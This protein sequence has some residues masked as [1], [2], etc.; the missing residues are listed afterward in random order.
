MLNDK[1]YSVTT[2][3]DISMLGLNKFHVLKIVFEGVRGMGYGTTVVA[4]ATLIILLHIYSFY[5]EL[6]KYI[7]DSSIRNDNCNGHSSSQMKFNCADLPN[8]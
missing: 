8:I 4:F 2:C 5:V 3:N 1:K 7:F 6:S